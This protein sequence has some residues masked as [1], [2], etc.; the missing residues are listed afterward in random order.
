MPNYVDSAS[1]GEP[2]KRVLTKEETIKFVIYDF[3]GRKEEVFKSPTLKAHGYKWNLHVIRVIR[4]KS[5]GYIFC[6][7][8]PRQAD[9]LWAEYSF[10]CKETKNKKKSSRFRE[11]VQTEEYDFFR[12][13]T[14]RESAIKEYLEEDGSLVIEATIHKTIGAK[15][16]WYPKKFQRNDV[17][18][19]LYQ[20]ASSET[21]DVVFS[22]GEM[23]YRAHKNILALRA[24][25]LFEIAALVD[26]D[27][28]IPISSVRGEIFKIILEFVY[29][30]KTPDFEDQ[31]IATELLIAADRYDCVHLKLYAESII[32]DKF[33][34]NENALVLLIL[35]DS[36][37]CAL[38]KE[39]AMDTVVTDIN[40]A[41]KS[42]AWSQIKES[43]RLLEE[44]LGLACSKKR[45]TK[46]N[47]SKIDQMDVTALREELDEEDL[48]VDGSREVLVDRLETYR[49]GQSRA[50]KR[51]KTRR[52]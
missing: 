10:Y 1:V 39:A 27:V 18:A 7:L 16:V 43:N 3:E 11:K 14:K 47:T 38:L 48:E 17:L 44:L 25:K 19:E 45:L 40:T 32:V 23:E 21:S 29:H 30:V 9:H 51:R 22:V 13:S 6:Y 12:F 31:D 36:Y 5:D 49:Q 2:P 42:E 41:K 24:K 33:L 26:S 28:P 50:K 15:G 52:S 4:D 8:F 35:A 20:N 46:T 37:S 34:T